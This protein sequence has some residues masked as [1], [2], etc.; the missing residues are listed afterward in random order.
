[1]MGLTA[2]KIAQLHALT[3]GKV[4]SPFARQTGFASGAVLYRQG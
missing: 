4:V 2:G 3:T 1:M